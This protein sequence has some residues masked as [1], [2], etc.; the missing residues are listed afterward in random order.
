MQLPFAIFPTYLAVWANGKGIA[1]RGT[2][3]KF[4]LDAR[5]G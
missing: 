3:C 2:G 4:S 5:C 1:G